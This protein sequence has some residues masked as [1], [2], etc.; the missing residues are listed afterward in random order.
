MVD[1]E[2]SLPPLRTVGERLRWMITEH[3]GTTHAAFARQLGVKAPQLSRWVNRP[4]QAPGEA[5]LQ[6][7]AELGGVS[8]AWLR[9]GVGAPV[10]EGDGAAGREA[11]SGRS[12]DELTAEELFR[13][14]EGVVRRMGGAEV[15]PEELEMRKLDVIE[16][17]TRLHA[18]QGTV[19]GWVYDLKRRVLRGEL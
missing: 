12:D 2:V 1:P 14:F 4:D 6:R 11:G 3:L 16:G 8:P 10:G 19:P 17:L 9:Y 18:A 7:M 15:A 5:S 13:H